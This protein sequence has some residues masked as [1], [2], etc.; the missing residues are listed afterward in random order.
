ML[1]NSG[2]IRLVTFIYVHIPYV[3]GDLVMNPKTRLE[4]VSS[5]NL[6]RVLSEDEAWERGLT[7]EGISLCGEGDLL[8]GVVIDG[9]GRPFAV[10]YTEREGVEPHA[11]LLPLGEDY[12][13]GGK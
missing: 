12:K 8:V 3:F 4:M 13:K 7:Q 9:K 5:E 1:K 6:P 11:W 2:I 10:V